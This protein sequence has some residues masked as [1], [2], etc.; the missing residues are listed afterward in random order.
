MNVLP[1]VI[2]IFESDDDDDFEFVERRPYTI[3]NKLD[4]FR[5]WDSTEFFE[6]YRLKKDTVLDLL[7]EIEHRLLTDWNKYVYSF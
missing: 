2:N 4:N 6:R 7:Q 3:K 5:R 1:D